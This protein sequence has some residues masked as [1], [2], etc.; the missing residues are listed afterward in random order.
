MD[1]HIRTRILYDEETL[2]TI[3]YNRK[4][5]E[6]KLSKDVLRAK[7]NTYTH[8]FI[9]EIYSVIGQLD[10]YD[11]DTC[12]DNVMD[13]LDVYS[14]D[15][16]V[17]NLKHGRTNKYSFTYILNID[18]EEEYFGK[19]E[20]FDETGNVEKF[21]RRKQLKQRI[22]CD[23]GSLID[24][25][26]SVTSQLWDIIKEIDMYNSIEVKENKKNIWNL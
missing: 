8:Q 13:D 4:Q 2:K 20:C 17:V 7:N 19:S 1:S 16:V 22:K 3:D 24:M 12:F 23:Y 5:K 21:T 15:K 6:L 11:K 26:R 14:H 9:N 10:Y 25:K 18:Y